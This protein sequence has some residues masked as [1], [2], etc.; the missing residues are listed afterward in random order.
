MNGLH[1]EIT[2]QAVR[3]EQR[4][5]NQVSTEQGGRLT[6]ADLSALTGIAQPRLL[7]FF[8][9]GVALTSDEELAVMQI[10]HSV[11]QRNDEAVEGK[12]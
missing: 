10:L 4:M 7:L 3:G 1:E 6:L 11:H 12:R 2:S 5:S 8:G 9:G